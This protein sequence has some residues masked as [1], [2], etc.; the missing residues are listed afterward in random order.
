MESTAELKIKYINAKDLSLLEGNPRK[1][2]DE[3]AVDKLKV[4]V[5]GDGFQ[6]SLQVYKEK[7]DQHSNL[8]GNHR[9]VAARDLGVEKFPC[10]VYQVSREIAMARAKGYGLRFG[11]RGFRYGVD[12]VP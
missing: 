6:N 9:F 10:I 1:Q 4:L 2:I 8:C 12:L 7:S 5:K 11:H 3:D